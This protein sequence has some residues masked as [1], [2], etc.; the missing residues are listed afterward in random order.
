MS[1]VF[2]VSLSGWLVGV[3][4]GEP[5]GISLRVYREKLSLEARSGMG[6]YLKDHLDFYAQGLGSL[7][8]YIFDNLFFYSGL[9]MV[10]G[11]KTGNLK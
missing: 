3:L 5:F 7:N 6:V 10:L 9:G 1:M 4:I 2:L 11:Y 8:F